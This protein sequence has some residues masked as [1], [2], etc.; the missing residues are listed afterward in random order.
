MPL[1][2]EE[3]K[4]QILDM[5]H[6]F[7]RKKFG[8]ESMAKV[9]QTVGNTEQAAFF[10]KAASEDMKCIAELEKLYQAL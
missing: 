7:E 2:V 6:Q 5:V 3:Q 10:V 9:W 4:V 8:N 1:S